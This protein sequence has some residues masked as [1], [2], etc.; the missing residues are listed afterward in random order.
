[1]SD[2]AALTGKEILALTNSIRK[3]IAK[4]TK[5]VPTEGKKF[6]VGILKKIVGLNCGRTLAN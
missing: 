4:L 5:G 2:T 1:M 6:D 3:D